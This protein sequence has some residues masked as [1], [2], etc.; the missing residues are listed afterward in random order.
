VSVKTWQERQAESGIG[1]CEA[2]DEEIRDLRSNVERAFQ[3]LEINGVPRSRIKYVSTGID[4]LATRLSREN[5]DLRSRLEKAE[6]DAERYRVLRDSE[7]QLDEDDPCVSDSFF[8]QFYGDELDH[9]V[10][11]LKLRFDAAIAK[12]G[13]S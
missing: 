6:K 1:S 7:Y 12:E 9:A 2:R 10:D 13:K 5:A 11:Q 3:M 4:V 8:T